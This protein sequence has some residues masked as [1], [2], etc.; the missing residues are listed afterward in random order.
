M[1]IMK[2]IGIDVDGVLR[3]FCQG[4]EA[5][6]KKHYPQYLPEDYVG[7]N[8][9]SLIN[10][11]RWNILENIHNVPFLNGLDKTNMEEDYL[12]L[13]KTQQAHSLL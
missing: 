1:S 9:Y 8:N 5:V 6:V 11:S 13:M 12:V 2:K 10:Q 4:L 7:I 3:D